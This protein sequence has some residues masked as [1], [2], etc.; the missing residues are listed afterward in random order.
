MGGYV[1]VIMY[2]GHMVGY[3]VVRHGMYLIERGSHGWVCRSMS[4]YVS[5]TERVTWLGMS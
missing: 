4:W 5:H 3:V 1:V 2:E